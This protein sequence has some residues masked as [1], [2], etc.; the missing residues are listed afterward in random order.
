MEYSFVLNS[1]E[2]KSVL[3]WDCLLQ[4]SPKSWTYNLMDAVKN[5]PALSPG[6]GEMQLMKIPVMFAVGCRG[7]CLS[8]SG[9]A[10]FTQPVLGMLQA[11]QQSMIVRAGFSSKSSISVR[12]KDAIINVIWCNSSGWL[13]VLTR[14]S[15]SRMKTNNRMYF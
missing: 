11:S 7:N 6:L 12:K 2:A 15:D 3:A 14:A 8:M 10:F 9:P 5:G 4:H 13:Q 1:T